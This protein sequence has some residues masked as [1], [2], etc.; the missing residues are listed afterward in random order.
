ML[1]EINARK[2]SLKRLWEQECVQVRSID[3]FISKNNV[4]EYMGHL[5]RIDGKVHII[6]EKVKY[7]LRYI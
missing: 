2:L 6:S 4:L 3:M 5:I 7:F 1:V